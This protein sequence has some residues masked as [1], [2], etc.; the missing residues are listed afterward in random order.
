MNFRFCLSFL[1]LFF[2]VFSAIAQ[3]TLTYTS[4]DVSY[5]TGLE[6]F[7]RKHYTAARKQFEDYLKANPDDL[8]STDAEYYIALS[9]FFLENDKAESDIE[10]FIAHHPGYSKNTEA[11]FQLGNYYFASKS[12]EKSVSYFAKADTRQLSP[13]QAVEKNYKN[14]YAYF[15]LKRNKEALSAFNSLKS[16]NSSYSA[17]ASYYAGYLE[18]QNQN[19][20]LAVTDLQRAGQTDKYKAVVPYLITSVYQKQQKPAEL[21]AYAEKALENKTTQNAGDIEMMLAD[22]YFQKGDYKKVISLL[23]NKKSLTPDLLYRLGVSYYKTNDSKNAAL[24][25]EKIASGKDSL[26]QYSAYYLGLAEIKNERK[27]FAS[28][29]F[30]ESRKTKVKS[31][32]E[33]AT[34]LYGKI[35]YELSNFA[36]TIASLNSFQQTFPISKHE[37]EANELLSDAYLDSDNYNEAITHIEKLKK[38]TP[39]IN[40]AY[41]RVTFNKGVELFNQDK[42]AESIMPFQKSLQM[43]VNEEIALAAMYW[44]AEAQSALKNYT[45]AIKNYTFVQRA[46]KSKSTP[47]YIKS[48]YGIGYAYY[49]TKDFTRA[50]TNF[51]EYALAQKVAADKTNYADALLRLADC[52]LV[53][54][55]YGEAIKNYDLA[56]QQ[57]VPARDYAVYQKAL[58]YSLNNQN[59]EAKKSFQELIKNYPESPYFDD[60]LYQKARFDF[61][62]SRYK[63]AITGFADLISQKPESNFV[64]DALMKRATAYSNLQQYDEAVGDYQRILKDYSATPVAKDALAGIRDAL[65]NAGRSDELGDILADYKKSNPQGGENTEGLEFDAAKDLYFTEKYDKA[66]FSLEKYLQEYPKTANAAEACYYLGDAYYRIK[67]KENALKYFRQVVQERKTANAPKAA[68]KAGEMLSEK[69]NFVEALP[70]FRFLLASARNKKDQ[71]TAY[72]GLMNAHFALGNADSTLIAADWI[73]KNGNSSPTLQNKAILLKGKTYVQANKP[74]KAEDAFLQLI[75][76]AQDETAAEAQYLIG[77][78]LYKKK[79]YKQS[80][81]TL[82]TLNKKFGNFETWRDKAFLLITEDY[83]GL[84][85]LFQA[86]ATLQS[87]IENAENKATIEIAKKRLEEL[88]K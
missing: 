59:T 27:A 77:E 17:D 54:K 42:Y 49:N 12:Y 41:Q 25:L 81:E 78:L 32:K 65:S 11:Y 63:E 24:N 39:R 53:A 76:L 83:V 67:D 5:R 84:N 22:A 31:L 1:C 45:E 79:N 82:F 10:N 30:D 56:I 43:P 23:E 29:A 48:K 74:D 33:E 62:Q 21:I 9:G 80:L 70:Y 72:T 87:I 60:A 13:E 36:E 69:Q 40:A 52:E 64:P 68:A 46:E 75:N 51:R 47:Y 55:N 66:V 3:T 50:S 7:E 73:E 57:N 8:K 37:N 85:E 34:F 88:E 86:K 15:A 28:R 20:D 14:G 38:K 6:L 19:Y 2:T 35:N 58:T 61:E 26:G 44:T 18:Y 71:L 16:G 4:P